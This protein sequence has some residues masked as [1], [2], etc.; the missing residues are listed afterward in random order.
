[1]FVEFQK[2]I[3][4]EVPDITL[5]QPLYLTIKNKRVRDDSPT[6]DGVE[7]NMSRVWLDA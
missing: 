2:I 5:F 7:G 1:M 3:I 6:A 4:N